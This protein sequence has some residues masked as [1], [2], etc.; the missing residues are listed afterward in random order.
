MHTTHLHHKRA[1]RAY[2][3][4]ACLTRMLTPPLRRATNARTSLLFSI[5]PAPTKYGQQLEASLG[6]DLRISMYN[7]A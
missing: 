4:R 2:N 3:P 7:I 1:T 6:L 5:L